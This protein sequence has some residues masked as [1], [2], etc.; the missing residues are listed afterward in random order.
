MYKILAREDLTP[1]IHLFQVDAPGVAGKARAGQFII[2]RLDEKAERIPLTLADWDKKAGTVTI[3]FM[4]VG[5]GTYRLNT[6]KAGDSVLNFV[7]P[8]GLPTHIENY[9]T[10]VCVAGGVGT[11][12]IYPIAR[13]LKAKG[14][15]VIIIQGAQKQRTHLLGG[16]T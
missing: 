16:Q 4:D 15:R 10:V 8:L 12:P 9:G 2:V 11:A 6:L 1:N 5:T 14:N 7:G 13:E 3:V